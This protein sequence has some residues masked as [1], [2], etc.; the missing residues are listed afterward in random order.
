MKNKRNGRILL[1]IRDILLALL[2]GLAAGIV[3]GLVFLALGALAGGIPKGLS[4]SR[5]GLMIA[6]ALVLITG[7]VQFLKGGNLPEDTFSLSFLRKNNVDKDPAPR[8]AL[9]IFR[10][11]SR[12][13]SLVA[14]GAGIL[15][16]S[17]VPDYI[18]IS[19]R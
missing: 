17:A 12:R 14:V 9:P 16:V 15:L 3:L 8:G 13:V 18:L 5:S 6:G 19:L 7:A 2:I 1:Y 10:V 11:L 4:L